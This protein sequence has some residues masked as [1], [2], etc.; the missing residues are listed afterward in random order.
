M[1]GPLWWMHLVEM[2]IQSLGLTGKR[3][4]DLLL[5]ASRREADLEANRHMLSLVF[6]RS[7]PWRKRPVY[8]NRR[9]AIELEHLRAEIKVLEQH[10]RDMQAKLKE[11]SL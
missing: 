8:V 6:T 5:I 10:I 7:A 2:R 11:M 3:A 9:D 1:L 4:A